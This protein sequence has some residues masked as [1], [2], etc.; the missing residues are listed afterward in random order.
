MFNYNIYNQKVREREALEQKK[1]QFMKSFKKRESKVNV[2]LKSKERR[3]WRN[4]RR[5]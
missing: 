3:W 5:G 1:E 2:I 4:I